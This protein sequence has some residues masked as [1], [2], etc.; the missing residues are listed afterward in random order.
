MLII[1]LIECFSRTWLID[2]FSSYFSFYHAIHENKESKAAYIHKLDKC[3]FSALIDPKSVVVV[4]NASIRNNVAISI[5]H[6]HLYLN[7]INKTIHYTVNITSTEAELFAI[8]CGINQAVQIPDVAHII[9]IMNAMYVAHYIFNSLIH[10]YQ[11]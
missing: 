5:A 11:Y 1:V 3:I 6:V 2:I 4:S 10:P 7:S 9:V 8:R